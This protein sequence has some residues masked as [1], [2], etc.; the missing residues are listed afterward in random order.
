MDEVIPLYNEEEAD[1]TARAA[2][3]PARADVRRR[4][5]VAV[6]AALIHERGFEGLR[7]RDVAARAGVNVATL[8]YYFATKE[9]LIGGVAEYMGELFSTVHA[10]RVYEGEGTPH[11]WL[12]QEFADA[13]FYHRE[14]PEMWAVMHELLMR[15]QRDPAVEHV[16]RRFE[17]HG[18]ASLDHILTEGRRQGVFRADLDV[19][20]AVVVI[21]AFVRGSRLS[22]LDSLNFDYACDEIERW[23]L[24][25]A[26]EP[27]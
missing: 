6:A 4:A 12:R 24:A 18:Y 5:L 8:H 15:A 20:A 3:A 1:A 9:A 14:R 22:A 13:K 10:P 19:R 2:V 16:M 7:T 21:M 27:Q 25:P 11:D 17:Q 23:L 26:T